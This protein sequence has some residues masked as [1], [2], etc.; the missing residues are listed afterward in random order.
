MKIMTISY[1]NRLSLWSPDTGINSNFGQQGF[2]N[3]LN[4]IFKILI[5][6]LDFKSHWFEEKE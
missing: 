6:A 1:G 3:E 2:I 5:N 4:K